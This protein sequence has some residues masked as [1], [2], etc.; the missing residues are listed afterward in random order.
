MGNPGLS[1]CQEAGNACHR[2]MRTVP[3]DWA[4]DCI[5]ECAPGVYSEIPGS[6]L[7][8]APFPHLKVKKVQLSLKA[9]GYMFSW[10][11]ERHH[12][13]LW[14]GEER[15][16]YELEIEQVNGKHNQMLVG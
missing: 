13:F 6:G 10:P 12:P 9:F 2:Q 8:Q 11:L 16:F 14:V 4:M 5:S 3:A 7:Q 1:M 15:K